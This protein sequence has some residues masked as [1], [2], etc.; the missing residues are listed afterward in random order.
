M[1]TK[2]C[3]DWSEILSWPCIALII[4][5]MA[6]CEYRTNTAESEARAKVEIEALRLKHDTEK[7]KAEQTLEPVLPSEK[8]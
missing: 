7:K 3:L 1:A 5:A 4:L 6:H 8:N 2:N